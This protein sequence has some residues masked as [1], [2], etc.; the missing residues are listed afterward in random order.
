MAELPVRDR[1]IVF[2]R[3]Y[4]GLTQAEIADRVGMS[5]VHVSRLLRAG[6]ARIGRKLDDVP[7]P[8][9]PR[10]VVAPEPRS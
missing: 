3:F 4:G 9:P 6:L 5:Q 2:L 10:S 7:D 8:E 1:T